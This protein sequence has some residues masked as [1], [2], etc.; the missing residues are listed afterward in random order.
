[1]VDD[2]RVFVSYGS[3]KVL[4]FLF[5]SELGRRDVLLRVVHH[6]DV[7]KR[8]VNIHCSDEGKENHRHDNAHLLRYK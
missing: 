3:G 8:A 7:Q 2:S 6:F 4:G 5:L 1:M